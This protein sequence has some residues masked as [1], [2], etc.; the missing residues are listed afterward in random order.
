MA[1]AYDI[2]AETLIKRAAEK[3]KEMDEI[4]PPEYANFIK[5]GIHKERSPEQSDWWYIRAAAVLRKIYMDGPV[6]IKRLRVVYGG[7]KR[8]G[9]KRPRFKMASGSLIREITQQLEKKGLVTT[10]KD[11]R[12]IT[13][14]G[15]AF[16][17][18][19]A[20]ELKKEIQQEI[21]AIEKY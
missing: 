2:P 12:V 16:L 19:S 10:G 8:R 5:T 14:Q 3:M 9:V 4:N 11:G 1:T 20:N 7:K 13:P 21:P 18:K 17:D 6:G 15:R